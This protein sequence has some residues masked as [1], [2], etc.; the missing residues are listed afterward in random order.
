M[1]ANP[2]MAGV[3]KLRLGYA[4]LPKSFICICACS[5][6]H[7]C[8]PLTNFSGE[9]VKPKIGGSGFSDNALSKQTFWK[10]SK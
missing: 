6:A 7:R 2:E 8:R 4:L 9:T 10:R 1:A 5:P 3:S